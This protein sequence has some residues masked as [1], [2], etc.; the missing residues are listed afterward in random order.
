MGPRMIAIVTAQ[1]LRLY[2]PAEADYYNEWIDRCI[3]D[4]RKY[5][6]KPDLR[7]VMEAV[8]PEGEIS[9]HFDGRILN[10]GHAIEG[11]WFLMYEGKLRGK[12]DYIDLGLS[13][14]IAF[15]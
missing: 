9:D 5:F 13:V 3:G 4:I 6:A 15:A 12:K 1:E 14:R 8:T 2:S 7:V 10:P 11:A